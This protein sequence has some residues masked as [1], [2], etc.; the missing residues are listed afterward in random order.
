MDELQNEI[1]AADDR[2][3]RAL[4]DA[5]RI[6]DELRAEQEHSTQIEKMRKTLEIT[7]KELHVRVEEAESSGIKGGKKVIAKLEQRVS[8]K[9][10][11]FYILF[12]MT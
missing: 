7:I 10:N 5:T 3:K 6:A 4:M 11:V 9:S 8:T 1:K 12:S 2:A